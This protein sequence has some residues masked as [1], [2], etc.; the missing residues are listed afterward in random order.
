[1]SILI[2]YGACQAA[3]QATYIACNAASDIIVGTDGVGASVGASA[4]SSVLGSCMAAC[5]SKFLVESTAEATI[6]G[7]FIVPILLLVVWS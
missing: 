3:C 5:A 2:S 6:T 7:G 1:M 4:C